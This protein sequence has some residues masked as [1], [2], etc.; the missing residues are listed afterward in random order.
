MQDSLRKLQPDR[1]EDLIALGAL[2]RPGPM[3]N[4]PTYIAR[5][6]GKEKPDYLHPSLQPV[7]EETYGVI[8]YQEQVQK[9]AQILSGYTL[10]GADLLRRAMGKK[11]KAEM[12]SQRKTFVE[13]AEN[14]KVKAKQ[15]NEIFDLVAKFAGY[16]FNKAHAAAYALIGY[17]TAYL[18]AN[19]PLEFLAASMTY[20]M[21]NTDKL[22]IFKQDVEKMGY[23]VLPPDINAS[24]VEFSVEGK[25]IRYALAALKNVGEQAMQELLAARE[26]GG[27]FKDMFDVVTRV[28]TKVLNRRQFE[29]LIMAGVFDSIHPNRHQLFA[30]VEMLVA[31]GQAHAEEQA[32]NQNSLFGGDSAPAPRPDLSKVEEWPALEKLSHEYKAIGF[33]LTAHPLEGYA[34]ALEMMKIKNIASASEKLKSDYSKVKLAGIVMG[35]K[36]KSSAK[37]RFAFVQ[38]SDASGVYEASIFDEMRLDS[39]RDLLES[40]TIV[41][42]HADAK[43]EEAGPRL[44]ITEMSPLDEALKKREARGGELTLVVNHADAVPPLKAL[45]A[46]PDAKGF[47]VTVKAALENGELGVIELGQRYQITPESMMELK[48]IRGVEVG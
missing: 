20:D 25:A 45:L 31:F 15:A 12:D 9:I 16:G 43:M 35:R 13:G 2:Y 14:N 30:S 46:T 19:H 10:G 47:R 5:K 1:L 26:E 28:G 40:G 29:H 32:S 18:K 48:Q 42:I 24:Q 7:L 37:G 33:Y 23:A 6:H 38:L 39:W 41:L 34:S 17:Q 44:I 11:I 21:H 22:S 27:A 4:I 8:I 36:I 3:D